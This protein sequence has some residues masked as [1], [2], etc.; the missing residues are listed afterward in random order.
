MD[1][2]TFLGTVGGGVLASIAG[3]FGTRSS[4]DGSPTT[5]DASFDPT[6][7]HTDAGDRVSLSDLPALEGELTIYLG[8]GEGGLYN[9]LIEH[10]EKD[11]YPDLTL[12][13]RRDASAA[14]ANTIIEEERNGSSPADVFWSIDAGALGAVAQRGLAAPLPDTVTGLVPSQFADDRGRWTGISGRARAIPYNTD[15]YDESDIPTDITTF[16]EAARF[17]DAMGWAPTYGAFQAFVTAMRLTRGEEATRRWLEGMLDAGVTRYSGEF[18]VTNFVAEGAL[19]AGFA[20]HYYALRL[21]EAK[22]DAPLGIAFTRN[23]AG[24]LVNASGAMVLDSSSST[25]AATNLVRHLLT[26]EVQH[27]LASK[28]YEY[29]LV[30]GV[31][32]PGGLPP[33]RELDPPAID[34]TRLAEVEATLDLMRSVGV[35]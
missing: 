6:T 1:R 35:L 28:A 13:V 27:F 18:L 24:S 23:D 31:S 14:L 25:E 20:N 5:G 17:E 21:R 22:P 16:P 32:P 12:D 7:S 30:D 29:P 2:R 4:A 3:C 19:G 9:S 8:R 10:F 33:I 11:R 15:R 34:L 26:V